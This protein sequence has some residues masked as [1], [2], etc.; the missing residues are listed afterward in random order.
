LSPRR[1][2][3]DLGREEDTPRDEDEQDNLLDRARLL[4]TETDNKRDDQE[5]EEQKEEH[6][7]E[8]H[9]SDHSCKVLLRAVSRKVRSRPHIG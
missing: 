9:Q 4:S 5:R 6:P 8:A 1:E 3:G 2:R 7:R